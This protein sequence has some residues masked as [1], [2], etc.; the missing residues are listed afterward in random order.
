MEIKI[1]KSAGFCFGV[2]RAV[3]LAYKNQHIPNTYTLGPIIHNE[4]VIEDLKQRG[5]CPITQLNDTCKN[6][7]IRSHGVTPEIYQQAQQRDINLLDA[8]CPY[9]KKIHVLV[10]KYTNS[11]KSILLIGDKNHPEIIGINGWGKNKCN[12]I[13]DI[14]DPLLG[15]LDKTNQYFV[16][17]QT[18]YKKE[19]VEEVLDYIS[20]HEFDY[21]YKNTICASTSKRQ[22]EA[23]K[24]AYEVDIMIVVGSKNSSNTQKLYEICKSVCENTYCVQ[25]KDELQTFNLKYNKVGI[26][27][28]ASTPATVITGILDYLKIFKE[29]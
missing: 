20:K 11:G 17:S 12:I 10:E 29:K 1:A 6:I 15:E 8:T 21:I 14:N 22:D 16:V 26:T 24:I 5:I 4:T 23:K 2:Q 13:K 7:I 25:N 9:V 3:D 27:A 19:I 18:T 28:G